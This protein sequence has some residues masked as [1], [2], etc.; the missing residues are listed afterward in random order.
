MLYITIP[1]PSNYILSVDCTCRLSHFLICDFVL[2]VII[3]CVSLIVSIVL[4]IDV[5]HECVAKGAGSVIKVSGDFYSCSGMSCP[6]FYV[7]QNILVLP[8]ACQDNSTK[9]ICT[10]I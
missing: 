1:F 3:T 7:L 9:N 10:R 6:K 8:V 2:L 4:S 5:I